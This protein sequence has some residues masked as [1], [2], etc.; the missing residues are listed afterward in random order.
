MT[1]ETLRILQYSP[2]P[3]RYFVWD[4]RWVGRNGLNMHCLNITPCDSDEDVAR[5]E[6]RKGFH[7]WL[8]GDE[9]DEV[10]RVWY[11][12]QEVEDD[13]GKRGKETNQEDPR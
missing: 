11:Q 1:L 3:V 5:V 9:I 6:L 7:H 2:A 10:D 13:T 8:S 4:A 12:R